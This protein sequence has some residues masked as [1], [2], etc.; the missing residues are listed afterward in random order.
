[1]KMGPSK[2][3]GTPVRC[4]ACRH[5]NLAIDIWCERCGRPLDWQPTQ[6]VRPVAKASPAV[7]PA[8]EAATELTVGAVPSI[9]NV[10][11]GF[12]TAPAW[13]AA[14]PAPSL[15]VPPLRVRAVVLA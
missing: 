4:P 1:M 15:M 11:D 2:S 7:M 3:I 8:P 10:P 6:P 13:L 14:L 5:S 12:V 9:C